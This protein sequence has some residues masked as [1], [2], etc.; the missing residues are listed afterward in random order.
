VRL[1]RFLEMRGADA[2]AF[3]QLLALPALWVTVR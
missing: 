2:G 1:K 3:P